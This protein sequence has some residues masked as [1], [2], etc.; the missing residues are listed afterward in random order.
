[1]QHNYDQVPQELKD[2]N[3]WVNWKSIRRN[4]ELTKIPYQSKLGDNPPEAKSNDPKTWSDYNSAIMCT[5][6]T[7]G[8]G[9]MLGDQWGGI[10]IDRI[11]DKD[12]KE[13]PIPDV[14]KPLIGKAYIEY[15]PSGTGIKAF[16]AYNG[17]EAP[18]RPENEWGSNKSHKNNIEIYLNKR[19]FT[20]TGEAVSVPQGELIDYAEENTKVAEQILK[21]LKP[22]WWN[23]PEQVKREKK[24]LSLT[25]AEIIDIARKS[26]GSDKF[27][28]L[29]D[30]GRLDGHGDNASV[31]DLALCSI[32]AFWG[33]C[34]AGLMTEMFQGSALYQNINRKR[35][36][37]VYLKRTISRAIHLHGNSDT[38]GSKKQTSKGKSKSKDPPVDTNQEEEER[39]MQTEI[40]DDKENFIPYRFVTY[41]TDELGMRFKNL[42]LEPNVLRILDNGV[43]RRDHSKSVVKM[44]K[45]LIGDRRREPMWYEKVH[46]LLVDEYRAEEQE[47]IYPGLHLDHVNCRNG[48]IEL[49]TGEYM[50]HAEFYQQ[51]PHVTSLIQIPVD[52]DP[53]ATCP[54]FEEFLLEKM[55][56]DPKCVEL[57]FQIFGYC[58]LQYVPIPVFVEFQGETHTGKSTTFD[59]LQK[60]LGDGNFSAEA[61]HNLDNLESRFSRAELYGVLA[62]I[63]AD[64]SQEPLA[65]GGMIKKL[66]AG[67]PL[68]IEKKGAHPRTERI[69]AT[70]LYSAN[71]DITTIDESTGWL[72]RMIRIPF[73]QS[74]IG[75][76]RRDI[77]AEL[78]TDKELSGILNRALI[79]L[80]L[81]LETGDFIKARRVEHAKQQFEIANDHVLDWI[82][83]NLELNQ[84]ITFG[85][86]DD[87][88]KLARHDPMKF[89]NAFKKQTESKIDRPEFYV[90]L[91]QWANV[92]K[93]KNGK[94]YDGTKNG[95]YIEGLAF[96]PIDEIY[97]DNSD[98]D[99][100]PF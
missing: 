21:Q 80:R 88:P 48:F 74:H 39:E 54:R 15:S 96:A 66:S 50:T 30:D 69:F 41:L 81:L 78:T 6:H 37:E 10:D 71:Y 2:L 65:G 63:D 60:F 72:S 92:N 31:A 11:Y 57:I 64:S 55:N 75:H 12:D 3:R 87:E 36:P 98:D 35:N 90:K 7:S 83:K 29:Y 85:D 40:F 77:V 91:K 18:Y 4:G 93:F 67:D 89:F 47:G 32:L 26:S 38:F 73:N 8:I 9:F 24:D 44:A 46:K 82:N 84:Y 19:Y 59:V 99:N 43:Y 45:K 25:T 100:V 20:V 56:G 1:M 5:Y 97:D 42:E 86:A 14:L 68:S 13:K 51:N 16:F 52:Y 95:N 70:I 79:N 17:F 33:N 28:R 49:A 27:C 62:N 94:R 58:L 23:K 53:N 34:D 22:E 61:I 76:A